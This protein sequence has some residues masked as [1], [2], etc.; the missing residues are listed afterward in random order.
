MR[1]TLFPICSSAALSGA[2]KV[3]T[4]SGPAGF[5]LVSGGEDDGLR[6]AARLVDTY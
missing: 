3:L 1:R 2:L 6:E 5:A 4:P